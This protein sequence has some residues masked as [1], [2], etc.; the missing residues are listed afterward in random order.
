MPGLPP[1]VYLPF[2]V[3]IPAYT[4]G[5]DHIYAGRGIEPGIGRWNATTARCPA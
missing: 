4:A 2:S 3:G 5:D 1:G